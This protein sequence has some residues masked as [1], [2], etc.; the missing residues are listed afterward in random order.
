MRKSIIALLIL[1]KVNVL[2]LSKST[3]SSGY[4]FCWLHW[5]LLLP[6]T[7]SSILITLWSTVSR[8][9]QIFFI[10]RRIVFWK[11]YQLSISAWPGIGAWVS[12]FIRGVTCVSGIIIFFSV[13]IGEVI[14][15]RTDMVF[16]NEVKNQRF[17]IFIDN[18]LCFHFLC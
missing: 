7:L 3:R 10:S 8:K 16:F 11:S 17:I 12:L 5:N 2:F 15:L 13:R 14:Y 4:W 1:S 6:I 18:A 9:L